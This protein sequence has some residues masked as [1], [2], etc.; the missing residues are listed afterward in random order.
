MAR[1]CRSG[2]RSASSRS[3]NLGTARRAATACHSI[4]TA[5]NAT[6]AR[7]MTAETRRPPMHAR[8][9][10]RT[11]TAP[12]CQSR[13]RSS[14]SSSAL[15]EQSAALAPRWTATSRPCPPDR[16]WNGRG[17]GGRQGIELDIEEVEGDELGAAGRAGEAQEEDRVVAEFG[18]SASGIGSEEAGQ[19]L[20]EG[21]RLLQGLRPLL[22]LEAHE[23]GGDGPGAWSI[24]KL[25]A[26]HL[27]TLPQ[28]TGI[29][30]VAS[31]QSGCVE[32]F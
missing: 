30:R 11:Y 24:S 21:R 2:D 5:P 25:T 14:Y 32:K 29:S 10:R 7:M 8:R 18:R 9:P 19:D 15:T 22:A 27:V 16:S 26:R 13:K 17:G 28:N 20:E 23:G 4:E 31:G 6:L 12:P 1:S 3:R